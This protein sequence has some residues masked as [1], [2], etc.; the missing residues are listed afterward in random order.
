MTGANQGLS[1]PCLQGIPHYRGVVIRDDLQQFGIQSLPALETFMPPEPAPQWQSVSALPTI[2]S[3]IDEMLAN[4]EEHYKT[5]QQA[6][7]RPHVSDEAL[8]TTNYLNSRKRPAFTALGAT[9]R[10]AGNKAGERGDRGGKK[11]RAEFLDIA[12]VRNSAQLPHYTIV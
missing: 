6:K 2:G 4:A 10:A 5:I 7:G 9:D 1:S 12:H 8:L 3:V 11:K